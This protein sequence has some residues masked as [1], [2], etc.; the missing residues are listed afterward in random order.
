MNSW[1]T[2]TLGLFGIALEQGAKSFLA[3]RIAHHRIARG[4]GRSIEV[5]PE[6]I[7]SR[8]I[9]EV[10]QL[11]LAAHLRRR[12]ARLRVA[13][14]AVGGDRHRLRFGGYGDLRFD[15]VPVGGHQGSVAVQLELARARVCQIT[16]WQFHLKETAA[17]NREIQRIIGLLRA[18]RSKR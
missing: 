11:N 2:L 14:R 10:G 18:A 13:D 4:L 7:H 12:L 8:R 6:R 5:V 16:R 15:L 17:L 1:T 9:R 3:A